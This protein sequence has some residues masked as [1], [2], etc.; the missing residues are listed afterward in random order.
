MK[1]KHFFSLLATKCNEFDSTSLVLYLNL[2]FCDRKDSCK[3]VA[4]SC[5]FA[6]PCLQVVVVVV[7]IQVILV[8]PNQL[9][10]QQQDNDKYLL[11]FVANFIIK[12]KTKCILKLRWQ[13]IEIKFKLQFAT[14]PTRQQLLRRQLAKLTPLQYKLVI[15]LNDTL[16]SQA[17]GW[18]F[19][20]CLHGQQKFAEN[21]VPIDVMVVVL[22]VAVQATNGFLSAFVPT[23]ND[24]NN[25]NHY[26]HNC[27]F[28]PIT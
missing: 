27:I 3:L 14:L 23:N 1:A 9:L 16:L 6:F 7:V 17:T 22:S 24:N 11:L 28:P 8:I 19:K 10:K 25:N 2:Y 13:W 26:W 12:N 18:G 15:K 4:C 5:P 20:H 21:C